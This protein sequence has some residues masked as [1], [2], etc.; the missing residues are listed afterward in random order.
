MPLF[1]NSSVHNQTTAEAILQPANI[2]F[3]KYFKWS[4]YQKTVGTDYINLNVQ[5]HPESYFRHILNIEYN[6]GFGSPNTDM[7]STCL[8]LGILEKIKKEKDEKKKE[9]Y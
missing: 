7:C 1:A 8:Q 3:F 5:L 9:N 6:L 2:C 4:Q